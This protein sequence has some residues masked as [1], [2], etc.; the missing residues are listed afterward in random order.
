MWRVLGAREQTGKPVVVHDRYG[1]AIV[2]HERDAGRGL[3]RADRHGDGADADDGKK[4]NDEL[5]TVGKD[6]CDPVALG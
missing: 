2:E 6:Q 4:G 5:G 1:P 3:S